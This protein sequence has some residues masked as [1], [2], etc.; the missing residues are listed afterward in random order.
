LIIDPSGLNAEEVYSIYMLYQYKSTIA[1]SEG[2]FYR[3]S[4]LPYRRFDSNCRN[5]LTES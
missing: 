1:D 2:A 3:C 5:C 4:L